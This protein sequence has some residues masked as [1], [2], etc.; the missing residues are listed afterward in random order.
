MK[1][2]RSLSVPTY[3]PW[4]TFKV[5]PLVLALSAI[6]FVTTHTQAAV[7]YNAQ[8]V[9]R[10]STLGDLS[11]Y[12]PPVGETKP[13]IM[14]MLDKSGSMGN[15]Y[16]NNYGRIDSLWIDYGSADYKKAPY[17]ITE[18]KEIE[19]EVWVCV[20]R[21][22]N[23]DCKRNGWE[24][25][26]YIV[27]ESI[28]TTY[29]YQTTTLKGKDNQP[30]YYSNSD[31]DTVNK[32]INPPNG[33]IGDGY[34]SGFKDNFISQTY[35]DDGYSYDITYCIDSSV[36]DTRTAAEIAAGDMPT[37]WRLDR[38]SALKAAVF[39]LLRN[40]KMDETI[41]IGAGAYGYN[42]GT[43]GKIGVAAK[44]LTKA[45][46][47]KLREYVAGLDPYGGTPIAKAL[48]EAGGYVL[49]NNTNVGGA[50]HSGFYN[51]EV[52]GVIRNSDNY[53]KPES[54]QCAGTGIYMLT[55]GQ[56]NNGASYTQTMMRPSLNNN[57]F[58]C[59]ISSMDNTGTA[60]GDQARW[61]C[62]GEYAKALGDKGIKTAMVGF[63]SSFDAFNNSNNY[64]TIQS[65]LSDGTPYEKKYYRCDLLTDKDAKNSCNLGMESNDDK[66]GFTGFEGV[67]EKIGGFGE[68]GFYYAKDSKDIINSVL[69]FVTKLDND[70]ASI[71]SGTITIPQD[72][73][74]A[75][76]IQPYAYLPMLEPKVNS[77]LLVWPGNL[78][79]YEVNQGT[80]YGKSTIGNNVNTRLYVSMD[81]DGKIDT[82]GK[83]FPADLNPNVR[84]LWSTKNYQA[85]DKDGNTVNANDRITAGGFY[86]RLKSPTEAS[87]STRSVYVESGS[88]L[89][90]IAVLNGKLVGFKDLDSTYGA[91]QK[92]YLL[93][94]L[95]YNINVDAALIKK[96]NE[97]S[98]QEAELE[99]LIT[100]PSGEV[101][102]LGG[103][104][105]SE[106][107]LVSYGGKINSPSKNTDS[108]PKTIDADAGQ[109]SSNESDRD[110]YIMFGSMEG[111][112]HI[113]K[114]D[115][116]EESFA[117]IPK[118]FMTSQAT[119]R[120]L[121][122]ETVSTNITIDNPPVFG[123]DAPW[124][125]SGRYDY[126]FNTDGSGS[127]NAN[128]MRVYGGLSKGG[129]GLY[130]LDVSKI[131]EPQKLFTLNAGTAGYGRLGM[132]MSKP[133]VGKIKVGTG[134]NA[135]KDVIIFGGGYDK[136]Y[137]DPTFKLNFS[138]N[139]LPNCNIA[140]AQGNAVY[141]ADA[142]TGEL[143]LSVSGDNA[144]G[145]NVSV[146]T[147]NHS[148]VSEITTLDRDND[149]FID[150]LYFGDL[151]GQLYR[152]DLQ[153][154]S[155]ISSTPG[156]NTFVR[157]VSR[158]LNTS[159][160]SS[161]DNLSKTLVGKGLQYRFYAQ[162][163][164]SFFED[165]ESS[166]RRIAVVNIASGDRSS[167][168]SRHRKDLSEANRLFGIIDRDLVN[169][170]LYGKDSD[171][172]DFPL[173]NNELTLDKLASLPF[174][175]VTTPAGVT[176]AIAKTKSGVLTAMKNGVFS[177]WSYPLTYFDGYSNIKHVKSMGKGL[178][179]GGV[180]Y[181]TAYSP[182]MQYDT[183]I[184][185]CSAQVVGGSER[186]LYCLPWGICEADSSSNG[187]GG[188]VRAG[189]GIQELALGAF[190][191]DF[192]NVQVLIGNQTFAEQVVSDNRTGY[193][194]RQP[195]PPN[196]SDPNVL[197]HSSDG[198][199]TPS[200]VGG[201]GTGGIF[202]NMSG[203]KLYPQRWY[204]KS[205]D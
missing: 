185:T 60:S 119:L 94:F 89:R 79:K 118:Q 62:I 91:E 197:P 200:K 71:P 186:Q 180:Y 154:G 31:I 156:I 3:T 61:D 130:G 158:V 46:K 20:D 52:D 161:S 204:E 64:R 173:V 12:Q 121:K 7:S 114:S 199:G 96:I 125:A 166:G 176:P 189:K 9:A 95:G 8:G 6:G 38:I 187:T 172:N 133:V 45:Q 167:P 103:V 124:I 178:A 177:G 43:Y 113:A 109:I 101:K 153:N 126:K 68:G 93:S 85:V 42:G 152:V 26:T 33:G 145:K 162:P 131:N 49:G 48:A 188:F 183:T 18:N 138:T 117:F 139:N 56:P 84:D 191:K 87:N 192:T 184:N 41:S 111:A 132:V 32:A 137:E 202:G 142:I 135:T 80:L 116:G 120:A 136:C 58:Q 37:N 17:S 53:I 19:K 81:K 181:M 50:T 27:T 146:S 73:L 35:S 151:G 2:S 22:G 128:T 63:G 40:P 198:S 168:L 15:F 59:S 143:I 99:N 108:D 76:N 83:K 10:Y 72:P 5:S 13:T 66:T 106:P 115:T 88:G 171:D 47:N 28:R 90:K 92:L 100:T 141:I 182:E 74:S 159:G 21:K 25:R 102:V 149:G 97:A 55:D 155:S 57:S 1:N 36:Q 86:A 107:T 127:V 140:S 203:Y 144:G 67:N 69:S 75:Q 164:V 70:I 23:G 44:P 14:L 54:S 105:H 201:M 205:P 39:K 195:N 169:S 179:L 112:L 160:D 147:M 11:I 196:S 123:V 30:C 122:E 16:R 82:T 24:L 134:A 193:G 98:N 175:K 129:V 34:P 170:N 190:S 4:M 104:L 29:Q 165:E 150:H 78:K 110:D 77:S 65:V 163:S 194:A 157:R 51:T 148:V 174:D